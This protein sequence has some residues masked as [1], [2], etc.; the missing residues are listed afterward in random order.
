MISSQN[1]T[2]PIIILSSARTFF[3]RKTIKICKKGRLLYKSQSLI[4]SS[5]YLIVLKSAKKGLGECDFVLIFRAKHE[6]EV[7]ALGY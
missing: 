4:K 2:F 7:R 6:N 5:I 1:L 3:N